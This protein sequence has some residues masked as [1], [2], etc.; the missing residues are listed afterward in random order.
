MMPASKTFLTGATGFLGGE[1]VK[2]ILCENTTS[3][4]W[5]LIRDSRQI[6][7]LDRLEEL[8]LS[9]TEESE[10]TI[11]AIRHRVH[12]VVGD[13][14]QLRFG[15]DEAAFIDLASQVDQIFHCAASIHLIGDLAPMRKINYFGTQQVLALA[16]ISS[17]AGNF[18]R[19]NYVS[20]AYIAGKRF[21][22][23]Y[24]NELAH[25]KG[26]C[27]TYEMV[28]HET[29]QMVEQAKAELP[30][31]IFRPS[32]IVG[33]SKT[34]KTTSFN[35]IYEPMRLSYLGK[36][37]ILPGSSKSVI[38]VVPVDFVSDALMAL[39]AMDKE[40]IGKTFHLSVGEN[41]GMSTQ[42]ITSF[43]HHYVKKITKG[44]YDS[45]MPKII[46]SLALMALSRLMI[47]CTKG[48]RRRFYE[49]VL[50]YSNYG[51]FYKTFNTRETEALLRPLGIVPPKLSEYLNVLC[52][53]AIQ[54]EFGAKK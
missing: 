1:L 28:K 16:R 46:H 32:I 37:K 3:E 50:T 10:L 43:C 8:F 18:H 45:P 29:E 41:Q 6:K 49:K 2:R 21:G 40:V 11:T 38:D 4:I 9:I 20:T 7:A 22:I 25:N 5:L 19:F 26:F 53:Y 34:G 30:I 54:T 13:L 36:L 12:L 24:E 27:N 15:L 48:K 52:D 14:T 33:D 31:T 47:F 51:Y 35:V 44:K 17:Q 23:I 39:S 42:D